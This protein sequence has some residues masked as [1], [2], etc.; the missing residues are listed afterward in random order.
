MKICAI[1]LSAGSSKRFKSSLPKYLHSIAGKSILDYNLDSIRSIK[2]INK[3]QIIS[4]K[5][6]KKFFIERGINPFIQNPINGTGGAIKQIYNA[7]KLNSDY[8]LVTLSDT[9]IFDYKI[10]RNFINKSITSKTDLSVLS[11]E[12]SNP[13]GYGRIMIKNKKFESIVEENDCDIDQKK[14]NLINTGIF[15]LSKRA[16][17]NINLIKKNLK[18]KEFYI[19]DLIEICHKKKLKIDTYQNLSLPIQGVNTML[20]L[21]DLDKFYQNFL[22]QKLINGGV[23]IVHPETVYI[24][25]GANISKGVIIEPNVVLKKNV[26]IGRD[27]II[28]SFSYIEDCNV[29]INCQIGPFA[30]IRP[31]SKI[32]NDAKI[33]NFVEIKKS[34]I[35]EG[36]KINHLSYVGDTNIGKNTNIGA[37]TITCN[38]DG[39]N[40]LSSKIGN[41]CFIGSNTSIVAPVKI[42]NY[43]YVAAGSVITKN[44]KNNQFSISR[45]KQKNIKNRI[46]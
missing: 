39:K 41:N 43:A 29:G 37:G 33:G 1:V 36:V 13:H 35:S 31:E 2:K 8:Y 20:E 11:Q 34:S 12:V 42:G 6:N 46:K 16:I 44:V 30:R 32:S 40:K 27:T 45:T 7:K 17:S 26:N 5:E 24:E 25:N 22:K 28:K 10:L 19:T 21:Q 9:P 23:R 18:K 14:I 15:F 4:N 38:Y 3:I